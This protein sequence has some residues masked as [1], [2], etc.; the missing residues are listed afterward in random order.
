MMGEYRSCQHRNKRTLT[1]TVSSDLRV[2]WWSPGPAGVECPSCLRVTSSRPAT[3]DKLRRLSRSERRASSH[4]PDH[5]L[6]AAC[7]PVHAPN[8]ETLRFSSKISANS[9]SRDTAAPAKTSYQMWLICVS[10]SHK[11]II[12]VSVRLSCCIRPTPPRPF[13][14]FRRTG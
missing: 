10:D 12:T 3:V 13:F 2:L 6:L 14:L 8:L 1:A 9:V 7:D 5:R 4:A 11:T